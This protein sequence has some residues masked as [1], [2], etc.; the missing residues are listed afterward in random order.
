MTFGDNDL[1]SALVSGSIHADQL[2][3]LTDV[4]GLYTANPQTNQDAKRIER[5]DEITDE[6][7]GFASGSGSK[8]GT[9]GMQSKLAAAKFAM[10]AGVDVFI[11]TGSGPN[12][13]IEILNNNGDGTYFTRNDKAIPTH[14]QWLTLTKATGNPENW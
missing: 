2:I 3:I 8:V 11:G 1:L 5:I 14:K 4:N 6:M 12:K 7:L 13:L 10:S 9:G